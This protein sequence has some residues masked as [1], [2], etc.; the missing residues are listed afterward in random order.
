M[1][2]GSPH[3]SVQPDTTASWPPLLLPLPSLT[4]GKC[5]PRCSETWLSNLGA[6]VTA[7][8]PV[9]SAIWITAAFSTPSASIA[10]AQAYELREIRLKAGCANSPPCTITTSLWTSTPDNTPN[11]QVATTGLQVVAPGQ[12]VRLIQLNTPWPLDVG[13]RYNLVV[14]AFS[15]DV[16]WD[17]TQDTTFQPTA[18]GWACLG[19]G[20]TADSGA[21]PAV[22]LRPRPCT[23][24]PSGPLSRQHVAV[25]HGTLSSRLDCARTSGTCLS[26]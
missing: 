17:W 16:K 15:G 3:V 6:T 18:P 19:W 7:Y 8:E 12:E 14:Q 1:L 23:R 10:T 9:N 26:Y 20:Y 24:A 21:P 25:L 22:H 13:K 2:F 11:V 5:A 4:S